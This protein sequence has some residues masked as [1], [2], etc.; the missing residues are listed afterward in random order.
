MEKVKYA[1]IGVGNRGR[2]AHLPIITRM[3]DVLD[4]VAVCDMDAQR[5]QEIGESV[6]VPYYS[7][8]EEMLEKAQP[9]IADIC[10]PGDTHHLVAKTV[11]EHGI[12]ILC[13]TPIAIT[14]PCA[15]MM[16]EA[17]K[18]NGVK[19]EVAENV[20]R[21]ATER[22]KVE[23]IKGGTIGKV[24]RT[25][26]HRIWGAYH[27]MNA[28]RS[29]AEFREAKSVWALQ[30]HTPLDHPIVD[31]K[32]MTTESFVHAVITFEDDIL[33][34]YE[35]LSPRNSPL[36]RKPHTEVEGTA[37]SI[38]DTDVRLLDATPSLK[39]VTNDAGALEHMVLETDPPVVWENPFTRYGF[40]GDDQIAVAQEI[41]SIRR[42]V[43][44]DIE[45]EYGAQNARTDQ[46]IAMAIGESSR[47]GERVELP[48]NGITTYEE[49]I[50]KSFEQ[51]YGR[52]PLED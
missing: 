46:E 21:F 38:I 16:I 17:A 2:Y 37:G 5:A 42:A 49:N 35:Q 18:Q 51:R 13:E 27:S 12:N 31:I 41:W 14:V 1:L 7:N 30:T 19:L 22:L 25:Y 32:P 48:L 8:L 34:F 50:H 39:R 36:R 9:D 24:V 11:A 10:T 40:S 3:S 4:F 47:T 52:S 6:G 20:W 29:Y 23:I 44:E 26:N 15:D 43:L 33:G 45:P 28:L